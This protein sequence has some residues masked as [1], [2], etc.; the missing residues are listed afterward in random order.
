MAQGSQSKDT[1]EVFTLFY[2]FIATLAFF[3]CAFDFS[4]LFLNQAE[5]K[6]NAKAEQAEVSMIHKSPH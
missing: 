1:G 4:P 5:E 6:E 2:F 3:I